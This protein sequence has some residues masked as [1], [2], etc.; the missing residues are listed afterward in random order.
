MKIDCSFVRE[1][2]SNEENAE[3]VKAILDLA[4]SMNMAVIA[5]GVE[6]VDQLRRLAAL[7]CGC[8]QGYHFSPPMA[9]RPAIVLLEA[10]ALKRNFTRLHAGTDWPFFEAGSS[11]RSNVLVLTDG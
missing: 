9:S 1:L 8:A 2:G 11:D 4:R 5:E 6:T 7:G 10:E 3:I